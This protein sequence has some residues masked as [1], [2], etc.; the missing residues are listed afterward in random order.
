MII[1]TEFKVRQ[2]P[3]QKAID[4]SKTIS[5]LVEMKF[6]LKSLKN[7]EMASFSQDRTM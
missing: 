6:I 2:R 3:W 5:I 4:A 1:L 7:A